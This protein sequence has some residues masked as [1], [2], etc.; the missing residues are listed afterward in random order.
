M[1]GHRRHQPIFLGCSFAWH[2]STFAIRHGHAKHH[3]SK[4]AKLSITLE[5]SVVQASVV[6]FVSDVVLGMLSSDD[7]LPVMLEAIVN[8]KFSAR[9]NFIADLIHFCVWEIIGL[10]L[11]F[12][13][14][15]LR[16]AAVAGA[17][18][19]SSSPECWPSWSWWR[20]P[21]PVRI[22]T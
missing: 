9:W 13:P 22:R 14:V 11:G 1:D 16:S 12:R 3:L 5:T 20:G 17:L 19:S 2:W 15:G 8:Q 10:V 6:S 4:F 18:T 7:R 21:V